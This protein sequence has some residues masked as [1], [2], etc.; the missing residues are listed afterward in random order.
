MWTVIIAVVSGIF[1]RLTSWLGMVVKDTA[2][3][4]INEAVKTPEFTATTKAESVAT[5][6]EQKRVVEKIKQ[7][8][9]WEASHKKQ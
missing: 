9:L 2:V 1:S 4:V 3:E 6:E 8:K 7:S 5:P